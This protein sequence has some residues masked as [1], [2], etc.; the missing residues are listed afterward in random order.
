MFGLPG[1]RIRLPKNQ[2]D[3]L[4]HHLLDF[5]ASSVRHDVFLLTISEINW[6]FIALFLG[7]YQGIKRLGHDGQ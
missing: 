4:N 1:E 5:L 6:S 3:R 7:F 2:V